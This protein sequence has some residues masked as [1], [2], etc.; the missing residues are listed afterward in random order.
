MC[1]H[2]AQQRPNTPLT[3]LSIGRMYRSMV[4]PFRCFCI[5]QIVMRVTQRIRHTIDGSVWRN[6]EI[7]N[8][9]I[10][11]GFQRKPFLCVGSNAYV[12]IKAFLGYIKHSWALFRSW[13]VMFLL[14]YHK[15]AVYKYRHKYI[16]IKWLAHLMCFYHR[17][18]VQC[19]G[20]KW[21]EKLEVLNGTK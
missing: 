19:Q 16:I 18:R 3:I 5:E 12:L 17:K 9:L 6:K 2:C 20:R 15:V 4:L 13:L 8:F 10:S 1:V 21:R 14:L 7:P 11:T